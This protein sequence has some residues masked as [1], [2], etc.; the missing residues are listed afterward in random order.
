VKNRC[1]AI[2]EFGD[3]L[4][5]N[6]CTFHCQLPEGH[7]G[8]HRELGKIDGEYPYVLEWEGDMRDFW[9]GEKEEK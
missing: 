5:D 7:A 3:D 8:K 2:I 6:S 4:G 9:E 1:Q